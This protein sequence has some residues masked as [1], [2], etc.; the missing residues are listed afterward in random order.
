MIGPDGSEWLTI[1][2]AAARL[3]V[4]R[5]TVSSWRSRGK[6]AGHRIGR[7]WYV[8]WDDAARAEHATRDRYLTQR[9]AN[10]TLDDQGQDCP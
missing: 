7:R 3:S 4:P 5:G 6:V 1:D 10:C 8:S 2:E 9:G